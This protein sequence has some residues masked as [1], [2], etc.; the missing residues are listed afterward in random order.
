MVKYL[1][2]LLSALIIEIAS[3]FYIA[4]VSEKNAL[5]MVIMASLGPF[6]GLPFTG[7]MVESETWR[8]RIQMA[9]ALSLGYVLGSTVVILFLPT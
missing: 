5:G 2:I 8:E 1:V 4:F 6:L 7:Y 3:T 9:L